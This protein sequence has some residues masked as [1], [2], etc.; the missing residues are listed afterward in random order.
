L[1]LARK[2]WTV[3]AGVRS[4]AAQTDLGALHPNIRPLVLDVKEPD[5]IKEAAHQV[6]KEVGSIKGLVNNAGKGAM[7][8]AEFFPLDTFKDVFD[9]N[10]FGVLACSQAFL[11]LLRKSGDGRIINMSSVAGNLALPMFGAYTA[12]KHA[13]EGL[14]DCMRFEL[15]PHGIKVVLIKPGPVKTPIWSKSRDASRQAVDT[16]SQEARLL[17][18]DQIDMME[19][20]SKQSEDNGIEAEEV[21]ELV[22]TALMEPQPRSRYIVGRGAPLTMLMKRLLPDRLWDPILQSSMRREQCM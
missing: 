5:S 21:A 11:P 19:R 1:Y 3:Y 12:S 15:Q 8:P 7:C 6:E 22:Y 10:V 14:S 9:V 13:L 18:E 17:Y 20:M 2:G 16:L 4:E